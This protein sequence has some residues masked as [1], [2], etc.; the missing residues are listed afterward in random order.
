MTL[1]WD[2]IEAYLMERRQSAVDQLLAAA[3]ER[4]MWVLQGRLKMLKELLDLP[5]HLKE[6][7][8]ARRP[9]GGSS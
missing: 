1:Q 9:T 6:R 5:S 3:D 2:E 4:A 8:E 7:R